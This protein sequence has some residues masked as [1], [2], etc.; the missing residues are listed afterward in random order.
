MRDLSTVWSSHW[1]HLEPPACCQTS[2]SSPSKR[3]QRRKARVWVHLRMFVKRS[4]VRLNDRYMERL[5]VESDRTM[6]RL[7]FYFVKTKTVLQVKQI[8][9]SFFPYLCYVLY[10]N[11]TKFILR[12]NVTEK[13]HTDI[14]LDQ[15]WVT[16][17]RVCI[18]GCVFMFSFCIFTFPVATSWFAYLT[19]CSAKR[20]DT[21]VSVIFKCGNCHKAVTPDTPRALLLLLRSLSGNN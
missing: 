6:D 5:C 4:H 8:R 14:R 3:S 2:I 9:V 19:G 13:A 1:K 16:W 15:R 21:T 7:K 12:L 18:Y 20:M 10:R 11:D 17:S